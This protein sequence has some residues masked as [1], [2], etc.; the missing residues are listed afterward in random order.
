MV[1]CLHVSTLPYTLS[2]VN[3]KHLSIMS[4]YIMAAPTFKLEKRQK[5]KQHKTSYIRNKTNVWNT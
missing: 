5:N 2:L 4:I 1:T 3:G